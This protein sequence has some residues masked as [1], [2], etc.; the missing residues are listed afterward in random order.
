MSDLI[1]AGVI[2]LFFIV[3]GLY[4]GFCEKY[5]MVDSPP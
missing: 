5:D 1:F 4:A 2:V 3:G